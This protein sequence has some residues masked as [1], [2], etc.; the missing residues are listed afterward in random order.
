MLA[1]QLATARPAAGR[2]SGPHRVGAR[3]STRLAELV[4]ET[5]AVDRVERMIAERV[6]D[7]LAALDD[8][9]DRPDGAHRADRS[10]HRRHQP[11]GLMS[12]FVKEVVTCGR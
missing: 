8:R 6:A 10:G 4:A 11:A 12:D 3:E 2:W 1:R 5:G 7:A 9:A